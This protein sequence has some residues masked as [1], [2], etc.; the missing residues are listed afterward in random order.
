MQA[1]IYQQDEVNQDSEADI[2]KFMEDPG[3]GDGCQTNAPKSIQ[4]LDLNNKPL[5]LYFKTT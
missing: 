2:D 3:F 1:Y 5:R 4:V